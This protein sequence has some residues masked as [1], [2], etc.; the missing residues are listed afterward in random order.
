MTNTGSAS[1]LRT[2]SGI[3]NESIFG[4]SI[5]EPTNR[6]NTYFAPGELA[7][8][9]HGGMHSANCNN[10]SNPSQSQFGFPNVSCRLARGFKWNGLTRYFPHVSEAAK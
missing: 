4:Q 2:I 8:I 1:Y 5:R 9:T 6:D 7:S 3:G 10:T